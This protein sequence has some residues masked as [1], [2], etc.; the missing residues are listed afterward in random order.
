MLTEIPKRPK[1]QTANTLLS[2]VKAFLPHVLIPKSIRV[3][4]D[5]KE[6]LEGKK[7]GT[8]NMYNSSSKFASSFAFFKVCSKLCPLPSVT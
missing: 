8:M 3:R 7:D 5:Q 1:P 4:G 6:E 2:R